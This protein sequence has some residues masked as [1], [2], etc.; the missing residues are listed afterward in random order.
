MFTLLLAGIKKLISCDPLLSLIFESIKV[1]TLSVTLL[2]CS[3]LLAYIHISDV[4]HH[5]TLVVV[6]CHQ[7]FLHSYNYVCESIQVD[8]RVW[9]FLL[10]SSPLSLLPPSPCCSSSCPLGTYCRTC[11]INIIIISDSPG[12]YKV[13]RQRNFDWEK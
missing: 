13:S 6:I 4:H 10:L 7:A 5:N 3:D 12:V 8:E 9:E 1:P 11:L 2:I